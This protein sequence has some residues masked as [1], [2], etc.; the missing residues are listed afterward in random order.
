MVRGVV[1]QEGG[2]GHE[3]EKAEDGALRWSGFGAVL[4]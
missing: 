1:R 4:V 3:E 2:G